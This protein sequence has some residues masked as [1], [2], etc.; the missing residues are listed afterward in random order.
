M[1]LNIIRVREWM[2]IIRLLFKLYSQLK[3]AAALRLIRGEGMITFFMNN[4]RIKG[5]YKSFFG[6]FLYRV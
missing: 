2:V 4:C 5:V 1:T 6:L 3:S